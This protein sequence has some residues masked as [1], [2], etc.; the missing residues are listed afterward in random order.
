MHEKR[1]GYYAVIPAEVRYDDQLQA[2]AKLLY[3]EISALLNEEGYCFAS[4]AYF[5][6]LYEVTERAISGWISKLQKRGYIAVTLETSD[7]DQVSNRKIRLSVS[8]PDG[9]GVE[10]IFHPP[11]K[12][13]PGGVE[14]N[15]QDTN[16]SN[17]SINKENKKESPPALPETPPTEDAKPRRRREVPKL[18]ED[19]IEVLF[20]AWIREVSQDGWSNKMRNDLYRAIRLFLQQ[21]IASG[22]PMQTQP[23]V[24]ALCNKL[25]RYSDGNVSVMIDMLETA[26]ACNWRSVFKPKAGPASTPAQPQEEKRWL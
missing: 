26:A 23:S 19:E 13:F 7:D 3:G 16:I 6:Q 1:P 15:F 5:A 14:E 18:G 4:N 11:R 24:T 22:K 10:K 12:D 8:V 2:N 21:R 25:M 9:Q 20:I 17:T